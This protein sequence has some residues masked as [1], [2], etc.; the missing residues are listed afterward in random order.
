MEDTVF[1]LSTNDYYTYSVS[2]YNP[3]VG[4]G[5]GGQYNNIQVVPYKDKDKYPDLET[6]P[7]YYESNVY[8]FGRK[9]FTETG[10]MYQDQKKI[11]GIKKFGPFQGAPLIRHSISQNDLPCLRIV[12]WNIDKNLLSVFK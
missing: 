11:A 4:G 8:P 2:T 10:V 1:I 12:L 3:N 6:K 5:G 7:F 9:E